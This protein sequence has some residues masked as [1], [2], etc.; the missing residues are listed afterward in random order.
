MNPKRTKAQQ[1]LLDRLPLDGS[2]KNFNGRARS[3]VEALAKE[4]VIT[5]EYDLRPAG[6][7]GRYT[8]VYKVRRVNK[9]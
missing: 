1:V 3:M 5:Y 2:P 4:G 6:R 9:P 8:E 7:T